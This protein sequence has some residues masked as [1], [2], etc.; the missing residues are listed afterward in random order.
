[1]RNKEYRLIDPED[2]SRRWIITIDELGKVSSFVE[3]DVL[4]ARVEKL[5]S[6]ML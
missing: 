2:P 1:M 5:E 6:K 3:I 4:K